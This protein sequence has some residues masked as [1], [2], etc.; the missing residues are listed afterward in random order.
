VTDKADF[1]AICLAKCP[2]KPIEGPIML[3]LQ[4]RM[5]RPKSHFGAKGLKPTAPKFHTSKPDSDNLGKLILDALNGR[6]WRD[7]S[8][9]CKLFIT[10]TYS[11][12]PQTEIF[13]QPI[14]L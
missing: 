2:E 10:K 6:F 12:T 1:L 7:D 9:I 5:P 3:T 4:F 11:E 14:I 13:L 8:Q